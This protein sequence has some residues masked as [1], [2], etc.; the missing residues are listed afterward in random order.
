TL[1]RHENSHT[2]K[3][4]FICKTCGKIFYKSSCLSQHERIHLVDAPYKCS[5]CG[6]GFKETIRM[7]EHRRI[8][9]GEK[10]FQCDNCSEK[11]RIKP[12]LKEHLEKCAKKVVPLQNYQCEYCDQ[13]FSSKNLLID[14]SVE[15]HSGHLSTEGRCKYCDL[16]FK[17][18]PAL[19]EHEMQ[20]RLPDAIE[21]NQCGRIFKQLANLR[22]HLRLHS[23]NATPYKCDLCGKS[24]SQS[25]TMKVHRR[26]HTGEKPYKCDLCLKSFH[27]SS[28]KN[29]HKRSHFEK[30]SKLFLSSCAEHSLRKEDEKMD[31]AQG[32]LQPSVLQLELN[33]VS[34]SWPYDC[35]L[36][37]V[38]IESHAECAPSEEDQSAQILSEVPDIDQ[39]TSLGFSGNDSDSSEGHKLADLKKLFHKN[40]PQAKRRSVGRPRKHPK[41]SNVS[42]TS[43][44][45][46]NNEYQIDET[47]AGPDELEKE[48]IT[49]CYICQ[50]GFLVRAE[51]TLHLQSEHTKDIPFNCSMCVSETITNLN[52]LNL[53]HMQHDPTLKR[54]CLYCPARFSCGQAVSRHMRNLHQSQYNIDADRNR[55]FVCRYCAQKFTKKYDLEKHEKKHLAEGS[56]DGDY[57]KRELMCYICNDFMA[58]SREDLN[59]HVNV[60]SDWL[61]Y[62]C[63]KCDD[64]LINSTR[65]LREH[66]RQ[67]AEGLAIKC[68]YCEQRFVSLADCQHHE[69]RAHVNEKQLDELQ[70]AKIQSE[71]HDT[72][73]IVVDGQ[74]RFQCDSCDR[75][76]S[77]V[78]TLR[79]H[80]NI[81]AVDKTFECKYCGKVFNKPSSLAMH[82]KRN[83]D[84]DSPFSCDVCDKRF[85]ETSRLIDHRRTHS[86][87]KPF[88]CEV[89][90]KCFRVRQVLKEHKLSCLGAEA[91]HPC[92]C[93]FCSQTF[94]NLSTALQHVKSSHETDI[95]DMK[96]RY[97]DLIFREAESLVE[98]EFRHTLPGIISCNVCNRI[99]KHHKNLMRHVKMHADKPVAHMCEKCGKTFTQKGSL[100]IHRRIHTGE[101][102]FTCELCHKGF[103]DKKEM[104]RHYTSH[105]NPQSKLYIPHAQSVA[106]PPE[107]G[108]T[109][110]KY[111]TYNCKIC[112]RQFTSSSNLA[113]HVTTH[114]GEKKYVC[115]FCDKRFSQGGQLT[116]HRRIHTGDRPFA[117]DMCGD[118][119]LDGS[120]FKR[121][122]THQLCR[123]LSSVSTGLPR[124]TEHATAELPSQVQYTATVPKLEGMR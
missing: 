124:A 114:T 21:C 15:L 75:S 8:H 66:L 88:I 94:D 96:C 87:E 44:R 2:R 53:H 10:P 14:H 59:K 64:K 89:C 78:S 73:V 48:D 85:K 40:Q 82:E 110:K 118:R 123:R 115:E 112:S 33:D 67:H 50:K 119:F 92:F 35:D 36:E 37:A 93:V 51:L 26:A 28:T 31:V 13:Q 29:R 58:K 42:L 23:L 54:R 62:R 38:K 102:P 5:Y 97:C 116:V 22:R 4:Q 84:A 98:H 6:K 68:V 80:Q 69:E 17:S 1:R 56:T 45:W 72:K 108:P 24:F 100:T 79:R 109:G 57:M 34:S 46:E 12:Q 20:H 60:H 7:I 65:V 30:G 99:F 74:K 106:M 70:E 95:P 113:K 52:R 47:S 86:G 83:H 122:K 25:S 3:R 18:L 120:S 117:C 32:S 77:L 90:G 61:P 27:H 101:R 121:H 71:I 91:S 63:G 49:Q 107:A 55:R 11:F 103:V 9:T 16:Q 104:R 19:L 111:K 41:E 76:Y 39:D 105:F 81:H 43:N